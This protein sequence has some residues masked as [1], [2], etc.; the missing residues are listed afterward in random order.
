MGHDERHVVA[1]RENRIDP[2]IDVSSPVGDAGAGAFRLVRHFV[3][4][5]R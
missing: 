2:W 5:K 4:A 3:R 1:V